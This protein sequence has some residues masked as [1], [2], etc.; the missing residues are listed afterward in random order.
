MTLSTRIVV[1]LIGLGAFSAPLAAQSLFATQ[2]EAIVVRGR[3][4][5]AEARWD[6]ANVLYTY[7]TIDVT[8]VALGSG[9]PSRLVLKQAAVT[10]V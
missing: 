9:V 8:R 5:G 6:S 3:V 4:A 2:P 1:A 10:P 7:V